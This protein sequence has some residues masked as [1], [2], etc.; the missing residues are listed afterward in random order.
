MKLVVEKGTEL[1]DGDGNIY[2]VLDDRLS[3]NQN[4][5]SQYTNIDYLCRDIGRKKERWVQ[6]STMNEMF[7]EGKLKY[8]E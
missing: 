8:Y 4:T 3:I 6:Y 2:I 7:K 5:H 1:Q